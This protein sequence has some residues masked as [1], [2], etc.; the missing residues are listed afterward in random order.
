M[1]L[2]LDRGKKDR[3]A[4]KRVRTGA[5]SLKIRKSTWAMF[6]ARRFLGTA[7]RRKTRHKRRGERETSRVGIPAQNR[8]CQVLRIRCEGA[9]LCSVLEG[10]IVKKGTK[11]SNHGG[12]GGEKKR[13]RDAKASIV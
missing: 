12:G 6:C 13:E 10:Y 4:G 5:L 1:P 9:C 8:L 2:I 7:F 11:I 3:S